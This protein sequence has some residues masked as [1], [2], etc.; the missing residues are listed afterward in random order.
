MEIAIILDETIEIKEFS[1]IVNFISEDILDF[2]YIAESN[3][4][5]IECLPNAKIDKITKDITDFS[6]KYKVS[7]ITNKEIESP[8]I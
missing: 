8:R 7:S 1:K 2:R 3:E 6:E 5:I 4:L